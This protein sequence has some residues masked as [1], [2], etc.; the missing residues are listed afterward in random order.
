MYPGAHAR[1]AEEAIALCRE[2]MRGLLLSNV[3]K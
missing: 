3:S 2:G 1:G